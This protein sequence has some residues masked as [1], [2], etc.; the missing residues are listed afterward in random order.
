MTCKR[1]ISDRLAQAVFYALV[2]IVAAL[3][4]LEASK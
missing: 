2:V 1:N 4:W 3:F